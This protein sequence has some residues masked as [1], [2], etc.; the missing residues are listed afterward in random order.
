MSVLKI[1]SVLVSLWVLLI[2]IISVSVWVSVTGIS[3]VNEI[4]FANRTM[5]AQ[6]FMF[7]TC[8]TDK[9][10]KTD[11]MD[12]INWGSIGPIIYLYLKLDPPHIVRSN[13]DIIIPHNRRMKMLCVW[14]I[15]GIKVYLSILCALDSTA[16]VS[17]HV[18]VARHHA[19]PLMKSHLWHS[20]LAVYHH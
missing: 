2:S 6:F 17:R 18:N 12:D 8:Y 14:L 16:I 5:Q 3:L 9:K 1:F 20:C 19:Y 10:L 4:Q 13:A 15:A 11:S 7:K